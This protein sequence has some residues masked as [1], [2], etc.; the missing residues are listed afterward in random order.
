[1]ASTYVNISTPPILT[2]EVSSSA[3]TTITTT[4][5]VIASC[6]F[7]PVAGTYL[8]LFSAWASASNAGGAA[9]TVE[10]RV[11]GTSQADT[12]RKITPLSG[13]ALATFQYM[14][15]SFNKIVTVNGSQ[16]IDVVGTTSNSTIILSGIDFNIL[17]VG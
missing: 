5:A 2:G 1:M 9:L 8:V 10:L 15:L 11:G 12:T 7:T 4:T 13:A 17:K 16:A 3:N 14:C 6:T